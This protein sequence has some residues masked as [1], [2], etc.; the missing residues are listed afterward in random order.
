MTGLYDTI[1][2][3][4]RLKPEAKAGID[5]LLIRSLV[6]ILSTTFSKG[7]EVMILLCY[8]RSY[9]FLNARLS[10]STN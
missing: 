2:D 4:K 7:E 10:V 3:G 5:T 6:A 8:F 1:K 9:Y